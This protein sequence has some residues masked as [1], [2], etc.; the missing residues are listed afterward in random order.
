ME[1]ERW[2]GR[3]K[4]GKKV[5]WRVAEKVLIRKKSSRDQKHTNHTD[6]FHKNFIL[7]IGR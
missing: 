7:Y 4:G 1:K 6:M 5:G 2:G 3:R